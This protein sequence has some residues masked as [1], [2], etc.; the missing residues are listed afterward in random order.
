LEQ[1]F[2][3]RV[4]EYGLRCVFPRVPDHP[5]LKLA[6]NPPRLT[7]EHLRDWRGSA[8]ILPPRL[9][10]EM[11]PQHGPTVPWCGIPVTRAWRCG[12][13]GNVASVLI[14]KPACG[15]FL[16]IVDGGF[17]LQ[18]SPLLEY[19]EGRGLV[20]FC[21]LDVTGRTESEPAAAQLFD[22]IVQYVSA[23]QPSPRRRALYVGDPAGKKH[24]EKAGIAARSYDG[25]KLAADEVL[26]VGPGGG[27][28]ASAHAAAI[29]QWL[30][31][32]GRL[33]A[34]GLEDREPN[35]FLPL[36]IST[37]QAEHI[38]THFEPFGADSLLAGI[39]PAD[40]HNRG[41]R[42]LPLVTG[43]AT[44][45]GNGVLAQTTESNVVFFQLVPWEL[46][47]SKQYNLKRTYRRASFAVSRL[48]GGWGVGGSTPLLVRF[49]SPVTAAKPE[50]RWLEGLY[51]DAPE[52]MDDPYR[53]FRW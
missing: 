8:T 47:Y 2:G 17:S 50:R 1:R 52:E 30:A 22:N 18:Y 26:V 41:P 7:A 23:W 51:L 10:Y 33:L 43:G 28:T 5:L 19:R 44:P 29:R 4:T 32:G 37:K 25:G 35:A 20:L 11:R 3:F 45:I 14:E 15:D 39:G 53:F 27:K 42:N 38:A 34:L 16:P 49:S 21:Q 9:K 40:V 36:T 46:D 6:P 24:L 12:N 31:A 13:Y 48:L